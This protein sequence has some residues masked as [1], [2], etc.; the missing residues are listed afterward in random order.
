M[1]SEPKVRSWRESCHWVLTSTELDLVL[2]LRAGQRL[3]TAADMSSC[4]R[5][6]DR[7]YQPHALSFPFVQGS[8]RSI[9]RIPARTNIAQGPIL[10]P[11]GT[12]LESCV[13]VP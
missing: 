8:R 10:V 12:V 5:V 4:G 3:D 2:V 9:P 1:G 11:A 6:L 7:L 13:K